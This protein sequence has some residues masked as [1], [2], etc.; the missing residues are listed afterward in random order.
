MPSTT[1][2]VADVEARLRPLE[3]E[4]AHAWWTSN[5][6]SSPET[7]ARRLHAEL[8]RRELLA[9]PTVFA[10][11]RDAREHTVHNEPLVQ[12]QLH[13]LHDAF[14]PHQIPE[15]LRRTMVE[16]ETSVESTFNS[17]RG[18]MDGTRVDDNAITEVLRS[19]NDEAERRAAWEASKQVGAEVADRIRELARLRN[20]A[21]RGLGYRDHFALALAT[22]ELDEGRLFATLDDVDRVT[23]APF[24][25]WKAT[26]DHCLAARFGGAVGDLR[27]WHLDDPSFQSPPADGGLAI[28]HLFA[29]A[30]LEALTL[31]TY[32]GLGLDV[33]PVLAQSDLYAREG[34]SQ[35]AFCIDIDREGDVRV[36]CN[37]EPSERWMDTMLHEFGHALYDQECNRSLP[38]LT[39][40]A[41]HALTTEGIAMLFGRLP[42]EP[43]WLVS[44][45]GADARTVADLGPALAATRRAALLVFARWVLVMTNFERRLYADPEADL[46]SLW[47]DLVEHYQRVRRPDGRHAPDWAAKIHLAVAPVYYQNY[48]YGELFASQI[49]STLEARA[50]GLVDQRAAGELLVREVFAPGA[51]LRWDELVVRA[52]GEPLSANHL[53]RQLVT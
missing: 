6:D 24:A 23:T 51:S 43:T 49:H 19:S 9:D 41:A 35:H 30:D 40:S 7:E 8:A 20:Q 3:V 1:D 52:T 15:D 10:A 42:R 53:A 29:D 27:P 25:E 21:A 50:G 2:L 22:S 45:V 39:R 11:I 17:F 26:V 12:R 34:K 31:R 38:W 4:L 13:L 32:D 18:D 33:R 36:L 44:V 37:V 46:D 48:L 5:T 47:W 14:A 28:D 16:L